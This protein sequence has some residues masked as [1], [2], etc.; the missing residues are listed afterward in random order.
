ME[1]NSKRRTRLHP[2]IPFI[3]SNI[4]HYD[5]R[6]LWC[7]QAFQSSFIFQQNSILLTTSFTFSAKLVLLY[8]VLNTKNLSALRPRSLSFL[9]MHSPQAISSTS[10]ASITINMA[11]DVYIYI[12][13][14]IYTHTHT[15]IFIYA[16][17]LQL[18]SNPSIIQLPTWHPLFRQL[19]QLEAC[20]T[21][22]PPRGIYTEPK[23][24]KDYKTTHR[25]TF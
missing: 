9:A 25:P 1:G 10:M 18:S 15:H 8:Q 13:V 3:P 14:Y 19:F 7:Q 22:P 20:Q 6:L 21:L 16:P 24:W 5:H 23:F 11:D 2:D 17:S 4:S 12:Y